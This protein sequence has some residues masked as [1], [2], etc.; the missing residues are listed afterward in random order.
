MREIFFS[1]VKDGIFEFCEE[2]YDQLFEMDLG[3]FVLLLHIRS[4]RHAVGDSDGYIFSPH[5]PPVLLVAIAT[6][7][8]ALLSCQRRECR[9]LLNIAAAVIKKKKTSNVH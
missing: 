6:P 3:H 8:K 9:H 1:P 4:R 5:I 2:V 7:H